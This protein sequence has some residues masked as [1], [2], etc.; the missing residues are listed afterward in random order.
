[1]LQP[2]NKCDN[3]PVLLLAAAVEPCELCD[4]VQMQGNGGNKWISG[5]KIVLTSPP[6]SL[7]LNPTA[8]EH[9]SV[10]VVQCN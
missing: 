2:L 10:T 8:S 4:H 7:Q 6:H 9:H 5:G 3:L 1:M